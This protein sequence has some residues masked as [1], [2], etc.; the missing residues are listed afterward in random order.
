MPADPVVI[1]SAHNEADRLGATL[2][3]LRDAF[4]SAQVLV[5]DDG[6]QDDTPSIAVEGGAELVRSERDIGKGG[7]N[8]LAVARLGELADDAIVVLCDG[9]LGESAG[10]LGPLVGAVRAGECDLAIA[11]FARRVGGGFGVAVGFSRWAT[12][13]LAGLEL[14]AP[15]SGQRAM[16]GDVLRAVTPFAPKFGMETAM[17]ID[18]ARAGFRVAQVELDLAHRAT[19]RTFGGFVHRGRQLKDFARVYLS[20]RFGTPPSRGA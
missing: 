10:R 12:R 3:A 18:A 16:R 2:S 15:I 6:S 8:N 9:D 13:K 19:G 14:E 11:S 5:A 4:P 20:R 1:V 17:N 7:A